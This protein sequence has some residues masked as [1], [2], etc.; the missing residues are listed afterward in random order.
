MSDVDE[1]D[2]DMAQPT[3]DEVPHSSGEAGA[4]LET[5]GA[6][7]LEAESNSGGVPEPVDVQAALGS[8]A[9][10][11][12]EQ[13]SSITEEMNKIRQELYGQQGIGGIASELEKLKATGLG[14]LGSQ[15]GETR[16]RRNP[17]QRDQELEDFRRKFMERRAAQQAQTK[18]SGAS[19]SEKLVM[20]FLVLVCLY[21]GSPFFRSSVKRAAAGLLY[22]MPMEDDDD[23]V[24][25]EPDD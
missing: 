12:A 2:D 5:N 11:L 13:L 4:G 16:R 23:G 19:M 25:L 10:G 14:S 6:R 21:I 18:T 1:Q 24:E 22:G 3:R 9:S 15:A 8:V 17:E 7:G 20:L